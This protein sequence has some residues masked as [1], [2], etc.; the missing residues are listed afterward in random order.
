MTKSRAYNLA[1]LLDIN[2]LINSTMVPSD[3]LEFTG[4][5]NFPLLGL[6]GKIYV[7][8]SANKLYRWNGTLYAEITS[9]GVPG[10]QG[11]PG[12]QGPPGPPGPAGEAAASAIDITGNAATATNVPYSGLTGPVPIWNQDTLGTA[13]NITNTSNSTL[14][15]LSALS[16]PGSQVVGNISGDAANITGTYTGTVTSSQVIAG[17]GFTPENPANKGTAGG[18]VPLDGT[19]KIATNYLPSYVDDVVEYANLGAL[20]T[21]GETG[22]IYV[23]L[24]TNKTYRW[25]GSVYVEISPSPGST[26]AV[27]EGSTN[28]YFTNERA[29]SALAGAIVAVKTEA[30]S[31][32]A[33]DTEVDNVLYVAKN[34]SD[35]NNGKSLANPYLT[36]KAALAAA[37]A[38]TTVFVKSGDYTE[39]N[40]VTVPRN[41]SIVGDNLRTVSITPQNPTQDIFWL[42]NASYITGVT[43][44]GHLEPSAAVA[45][46]P[47]GSAGM[48]TTSPYVQ[49]CTSSTTTGCGMR[50][51]GDYVTGNRS[52]VLDSYTQINQGGIGI[53]ILNKGYAQ[54][55]SLFTICTSHSVKCE[56]GGFCSITNSNTSF[57]T[58]GL[59]ADGVSS[60]LQAGFASGETQIGDTIVIAG[61]ST[62]QPA[63][64]NVVQFAG[65]AAYYT[66]IAATRTSNGQCSLQFDTQVAGAVTN[67]TVATFY[68]RSFIG[69]SGHS[70]EYVGTGISLVTA[71]PQAG[72]VPVQAN[73]VIAINGGKVFY[74]STD[75]KGDFRIGADLT[76][77]RASG[78]ITGETFNK[79][80]FAVMT[81]YILAIS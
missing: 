67:G 8:T 50:I 11:V 46:N 48:I 33:A 39:N 80:M 28:L 68:Q 81:P 1:S 17:L 43:F 34:G 61:L 12:L 13:A 74:T 29:V 79:S 45:F 55:V 25:T 66:I 31:S 59:Y 15:T 63:I 47:N 69:A 24:D 40:P 49:N 41:V 76:F 58:Y 23:A 2:G 53:H 20:P 7:D 42:S 71:L 32:A 30:A 52:M 27:A 54:L 77:N 70:F 38:K 5:L 60:A 18:Y 62:Y 14:R 6:N 4:Y 72:G 19:A 57:G 26:D 21:S 10:P 51:N 56:S 65:D 36:I 64:N 44:R 9:G 37:T 75:Q 22:K 3:V 73:E 78:T 16:L 35:T